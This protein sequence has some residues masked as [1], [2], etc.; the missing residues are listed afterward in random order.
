VHDI[1][2]IADRSKR[3]LNPKTHVRMTGYQL[4][5]ANVTIWRSPRRSNVEDHEVELVVEVFEPFDQ[6]SDIALVARL[7]TAHHVSVDSHSQ[8]AVHESTNRL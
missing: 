4:L 8:F 2:P 5:K 3:Q 6:T 7:V 1:E